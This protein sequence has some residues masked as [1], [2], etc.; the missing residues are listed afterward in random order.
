MYQSVTESGSSQYFQHQAIV[1]KTDA[2]TPKLDWMNGEA[3]FSKTFAHY[4]VCSGSDLHC[5]IPILHLPE[6][7]DSHSKRVA[8]P[9][10]VKKST[11]ITSDSLKEAKSVTNTWECNL[12]QYSTNK[13]SKILLH[14]NISHTNVKHF[15]CSLCQYSSK[16][17]SGLQNHYKSAHST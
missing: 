16:W 4:R 13:R 8:R 6:V 11:Y 10:K 15:K 3:G 14:Y 2:H 17:K 9:R 1:Y 7:G 5:L 12:C